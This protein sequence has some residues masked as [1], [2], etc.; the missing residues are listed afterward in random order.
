MSATVAVMVTVYENAVHE[1]PRPQQA[2]RMAFDRAW[3]SLSP[4]EAAKLTTYAS[5][6]ARPPWRESSVSNFP[7]FHFAIFH[8][9]VPRSVLPC[10]FWVMFVI[11][12]ENQEA[13]VCGCS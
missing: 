7:F 12:H 3:P 2:L 8:S 4:A 11:A 5:V 10:C 13:S 1:D 9:S 6:P